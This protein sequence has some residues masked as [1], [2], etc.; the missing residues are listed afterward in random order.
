MPTLKYF[1]VHFTG[2]FDQ[3][4]AIA[5]F[6]GGSSNLRSVGTTGHNS[7]EMVFPTVQT[8]K[9]S[10]A[11]PASLDSNAEK[12]ESSPNSNINSTAG[13]EASCIALSDCFIPSFAHS[14]W[15]TSGV[16]FEVQESDVDPTMF[17]NQVQDSGCKES[18]ESMAVEGDCNQDEPLSETPCQ[19]DSKR[20]RRLTEE[21]ADLGVEDIKSP[22]HLYP[23]FWEGKIDLSR[24]FQVLSGSFKIIH[25]QF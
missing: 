7:S 20:S 10:G 1:A 17:E 12:E 5:A 22:P 4:C 21:A 6:G 19:D 13:K 18:G 8:P 2:V 3:Q 25:R 24:A 23:I 9:V 15:K 14:R 16:C 11:I